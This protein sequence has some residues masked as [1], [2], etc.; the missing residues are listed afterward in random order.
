MIE[1]KDKTGIEVLRFL[2]SKRRILIGV[3]I[4]A[5]LASIGMTALLPKKYESKSIF[6]P[7]TLDTDKQMSI[8]PQLGYVREADHLI[9]MAQSTALKDTLIET[10]DLLGHFDI[11]TEDK[12]WRDKIY[13]SIDR[14]LKFERTKYM[15]VIVTF[16]S[17]DPQLSSDVVNEAVSI[18]SRFW[19]RLFKGNIQKPLVYAEGQYIQKNEEV[20]T[21]LDSIHTMRF[22]NKNKSLKMK[23]ERLKSKEHDI[24]NLV[25]ELNDIREAGSFFNYG[26]HLDNLQIELIELRQELARDQGKLEALKERN[27]HNDTLMGS[28]KGKIVG[29]NKSETMILKRIAELNSAGKNYEKLSN[30]L[31]IEMSQYQMIKQEYENLLNAFEPNV[32][33]LELENLETRYA[34]EKQNM[35][36]LKNKYERTLRYYNQPLPNLFVIEKAVPSYV[37][38]SPSY[39]LNFLISVLGSVI[40]TAIILLFREKLFEI[41]NTD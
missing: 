32:R 4:I 29:N 38:V 41:S 1:S 28:L 35:I 33:S 25:Q 18:L 30:Q 31:S 3:A 11:S 20:M 23:Y 26:E 22:G 16:R 10:F 36:E 24:Q 6:F 7:P 14:N 19:E 8:T 9:Q 13:K 17:R 21:I 15:S 34:I 5:G 37:K 12:M 40:L 2:Y 27:V 39:K